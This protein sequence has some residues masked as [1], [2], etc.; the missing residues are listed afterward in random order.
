MLSDFVSACIEVKSEHLVGAAFPENLNHA[1]IL[2][3]VGNG[4]YTRT[5]R[6]LHCHP[7]AINGN[8]GCLQF[9]LATE[10]HGAVLRLFGT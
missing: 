10:K 7:A 3:A 5:R 9:I 1:L 8:G 2:C 6:N 4:L